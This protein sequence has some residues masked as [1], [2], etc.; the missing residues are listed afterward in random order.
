[1]GAGGRINP[2][3]F[4]CVSLRGSSLLEGTHRGGGGSGEKA[5]G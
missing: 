4:H 5:V 3:H 2:A 1:M